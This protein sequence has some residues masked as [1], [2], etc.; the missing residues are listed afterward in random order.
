[1]PI[2]D[3]TVCLCLVFVAA[4]GPWTKDV[5]Q[6]F[7]LHRFE[8]NSV[9]DMAWY[10]FL[11]IPLSF[12]YGLPYFVG[13]PVVL[14]LVRF[15]FPRL[16]GLLQTALLWLA[17]LASVVTLPL[18][19]VTYRPRATPNV[20]GQVFFADL[21][22]MWVWHAILCLYDE[23]LPASSLAGGPLLGLALYLRKPAPRP[24]SMLGGVAALYACIGSLYDGYQQSEA[25]GYSVFTQT[26]GLSEYYGY[27]IYAVVS[28]VGGF[29]LICASTPVPKSLLELAEVV[30]YLVLTN[31]N[32]ALGWIMSQ[33]LVRPALI[34]APRYVLWRY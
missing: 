22:V 15:F 18:F 30:V 6:T 14:I 24:C 9:I 16:A 11:K 5:A 19:L 2:V 32:V 13:V 28:V 23:Y 31:G 8:E 1:M 12:L 34:E 7:A 3:R 27:E 25:L 4:V 20:M 21:V 33:G 17:A 10:C 29:V 26:V